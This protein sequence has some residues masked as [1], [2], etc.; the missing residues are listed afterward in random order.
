MSNEEGIVVSWC[1]QCPGSKSKEGYRITSNVD[2]NPLMGAG[3]RVICYRKK[4]EKLQFI[5][6]PSRIPGSLDLGI[7]RR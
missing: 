6:V 3:R 1:C 4:P 2:E 7:G 5:V